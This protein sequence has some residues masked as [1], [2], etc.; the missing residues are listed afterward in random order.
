MKGGGLAYGKAFEDLVKKLQK[1]RGDISQLQAQQLISNL[2]ID[3]L[4]EEQIRLLPRE[5]GQYR[6]ALKKAKAEARKLKA[7]TEK[8][9]AETKTAGRSKKA[10]TK[11]DDNARKQV[12]ALIEN[13]ADGSFI[14]KKD[15]L[16]YGGKKVDRNKIGEMLKGLNIQSQRG[17]ASQAFEEV[18]TGEADTLTKGVMIVIK[19]RI[20][21]GNLKTGTSIIEDIKTGIFD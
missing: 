14:G 19:E 18:R 11:I 2:E 4:T 9:E 16:S 15:T 13:V 8:L 6:A 17:I 10:P 12:N 21:S 3:E 5:L 7:Q 20:A 1:E